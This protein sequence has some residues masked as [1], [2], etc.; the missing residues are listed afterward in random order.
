ML[1]GVWWPIILKPINYK[2]TA[3][4]TRWGQWRDDQMPEMCNWFV[5]FLWNPN[6]AVELSPVWAWTIPKYW[7]WEWACKNVRNRD[8][9]LVVSLFTSGSGF[10]CAAAVVNAFYVLGL[11]A[12]YLLLKYGYAGIWLSNKNHVF[13]RLE[14]FQIWFASA[15]FVKRKALLYVYFTKNLAG[16][17]PED[18]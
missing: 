9:D 1:V 11:S 18:V 8:A 4:I 15:V 17:M 5:L 7:V 14:A 13:S 12:V 2:S 6:I 3:S 10:C 16:F